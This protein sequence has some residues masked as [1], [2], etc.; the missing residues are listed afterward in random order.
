LTALALTDLDYHLG[1][2]KYGDAFISEDDSFHGTSSAELSVE[3]KGSYIRV[4]VYLDEPLP[5]EDLD[6]LS[7][8][9]KPQSGDGELQLDLF[10]DG[11]GDGS[12]DSHS[13]EDARVRSLRE[14]W[15]EAGLSPFQWNE[16]DGFD[17]AFE[18]YQDK[19]LG[20]G[21][22][23]DFKNKLKGER[24]V[25]LYITLYKDKKIPTTAALIDYIKIGDQILSFEPLEREA[26]KKATK[27]ISPGGQITYTIT[28]GNN[29]LTPI[30]LVVEE[31]YDLRTIF[32][33]ADPSPDPGS[34]NVW[35]FR[36]LPPGAHG[37]IVIKVM[38]IR[39]SCKAKIEGKVS[40]AGYT[41]VSGLLSTD[42][43]SNLITNSV[44]LSS[45]K[46]NITASAATTV[47]PIEGSIL[48]FEEH[49]SGF[50]DSRELL[51][52]SSSS[53][54]LS[55]Q[56]NSSTD[57]ATINLSRGSIPMQGDWSAGLQGE[58]KIRDIRW[59]DKYYHASLLNLSYRVSLSKAQTLLETS[60]RL[61]G[62]VDRTSQWT[63]VVSDQ[64]L[65]G[66]FTI[67]NKAMR[68]WSSMQISQQDE[69]LDCCPK[70]QGS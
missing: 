49:G 66:N 13:S 29:Q 62:M 16:L 51:S 37:Q 8:W 5:L 52:Y 35:T 61:I 26:I 14:S 46:F 15:S 12:Y 4:S 2:S 11:N 41:S 58:N 20:T 56:I 69:G 67:T 30:D 6:L 70:M 42:F 50:Y 21:N 63:D 68:K 65:A 22:L 10:L 64:R 1:H 27:S 31:Q 24:L 44:T 45:K 17:L 34:T 54:S 28:Y 38:T 47:R 39:P 48:T 40:G 55:R 7:M 43:G 57:L 9:I 19:T 18:K 33:E 59:R 53:I 3:S 36:Q 32:M 23:E 25:R 60:S